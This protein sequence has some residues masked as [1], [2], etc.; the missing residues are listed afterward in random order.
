MDSRVENYLKSLKGK[1]IA[2]L[3][4][5]RS[6]LPLVSLFSRYGAF[7]TVCDKKEKSAFSKQISEHPKE[8]NRRMYR[9]EISSL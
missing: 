7:I 2:L 5:G 4:I 3:G 8:T 1:R 6:N 9:T